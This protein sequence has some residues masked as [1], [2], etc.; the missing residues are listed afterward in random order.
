M[1][2][3]LIILRQRD[4]ETERKKREKREREI[5]VNFLTNMKVKVQAA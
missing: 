3:F 2:V 5:A 1:E 4:R